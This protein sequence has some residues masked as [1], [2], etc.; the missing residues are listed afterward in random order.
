VDQWFDIAQTLVP[1]SGFEAAC[2]SINDFLS[3]RTF[4]VGY[5]PTLADVACWAQL[6][7][8]LQWDR[9]K[10]GASCVHLA[11]WYDFCSD[12]PQLKAAAEQYGLRRRGQ[13]APKAATSQDAELAK[14]K[15]GGGEC[16][17]WVGVGNGGCVLL[18]VVAFSSSRR[19]WQ[20]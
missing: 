7:L 16:C 19:N 6:Q 9:L 3:L 8:T 15:G 5:A 17:R 14:A 11:R 10:K 1:G 20:Q 13:A 12:L 4:L 2:T 18:A